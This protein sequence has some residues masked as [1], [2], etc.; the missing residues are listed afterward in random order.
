ME[1]ADRS[2]RYARAANDGDV[3]HDTAMAL[4]RSDLSLV[5][6]TQRAHL[7]VEIIRDV[8]QR[9]LQQLL[10]THDFFPLAGRRV[11]KGDLAT[12]N[13]KRNATP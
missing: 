1:R 4:D 13:P 3:M 12:M 9:D 5:A 8:A 7:L 2:D 10:S 11:L 6:L